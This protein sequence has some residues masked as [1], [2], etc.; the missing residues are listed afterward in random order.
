MIH[1]LI[2]KDIL[3]FYGLTDHENYDVVKMEADNMKVCN[4]K[5]GKI[6]D[7]RY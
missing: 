1:S 4:K 2:R 7:L 6:I 3:N 5:T